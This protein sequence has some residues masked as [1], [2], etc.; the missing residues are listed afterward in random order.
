L[1]PNSVLIN[2]ITLS[3]GHIEVVKYLIHRG[4]DVNAQGCGATPLHRASFQGHLAVVEA[5]LAAGARVNA[6]DSSTDERTPLAKAAA[7]GHVAVVRCLLRHNRESDFDDKLEAHLRSTSSARQCSSSDT[8]SSSSSSSSASPSSSSSSSSSDFQ[9]ISIADVNAVDRRGQ[10]IWQLASAHLTIRAMLEFCGAH[11]LASPAVH[12]HHSSQT[13]K[14]TCSD[15]ADG[16][17]A[18][19]PQ[20]PETILLSSISKTDTSQERFET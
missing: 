18:C 4:A 14:S 15:L 19:R 17:H 6:V 16:T 11:D 2:S 12:N 8:P 5:L 1:Q 10:S 13:D 9:S 20:S 3:T 7:Q